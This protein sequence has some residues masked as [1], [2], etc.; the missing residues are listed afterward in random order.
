MIL[1]HFVD[2]ISWHTQVHADLIE[3]T[4]LSNNVLQIAFCKKA[5]NI[6]ALKVLVNSDTH[7]EGLKEQVQL[8]K[9]VKL[10]IHV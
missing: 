1:S 10:C 8:L 6:K 7:V 4:V 2:D 9:H 3:R 5:F